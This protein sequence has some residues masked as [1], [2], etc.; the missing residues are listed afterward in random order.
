M[1]RFAWIAALA[2]LVSPAYAAPVEELLGTWECRVPSAAPT[3]TPPIVWFGS[4]QGEAKIIEATVDLDGFAREVSGLSELA[5]NA[6]GWWTVQPGEGQPFAVKPLGLTGKRGA[7]AMLIKRGA[8]S[9]R[10][11]R[12]PQI[13]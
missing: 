13:V 1:N 5:P 2:A 4:A 12:L 8:S 10:C 6:D 11:L 9:Y 7:P 3:N